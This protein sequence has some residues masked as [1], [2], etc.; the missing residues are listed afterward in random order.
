MQL[1]INRS[2]A[3]QRLT[4]WVEERGEEE[5]LMAVASR[6]ALG[7]DPVDSASSNGVTW[8]VLRR[9]LEDKSERMDAWNLAKRCYADGLVYDGLRKVGDARIETVGL[10]KMQSDVYMKAA[11][12][13]SKSEWGDGAEIRAGIGGVTIVIG[14]VIPE[15]EVIEGEKITDGD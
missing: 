10:V 14:S 7:H 4:A 8:F 11:A 6:I 12:R 3:W 9:W 2:E 15:G 13:L 1:A 5:V